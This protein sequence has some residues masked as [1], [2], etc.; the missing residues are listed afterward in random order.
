MKAHIPSIQTCW[1]EVSPTLKLLNV[2]LHHAPCVVRDFYLSA[3]VMR[4]SRQQRDNEEQYTFPHRVPLS[5]YYRRLQPLLQ[6]TVLALGSSCRGDRANASECRG[7]AAP[8]AK[9]QN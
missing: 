2:V 8:A 5:R 7:E 1:P 9:W 6:V 4:E 3:R